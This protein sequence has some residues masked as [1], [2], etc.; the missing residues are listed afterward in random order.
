[1]YVFDEMYQWDSEVNVQELTAFMCRMVNNALC[2]HLAAKFVC[3]S[4]FLFIIKKKLISLYSN[5]FCDEIL[6]TEDNY[7]TQ[8]KQNEKQTIVYLKTE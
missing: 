1:M 4:I 6:Y 2:Y 8:A 3:I 5:E 7:G